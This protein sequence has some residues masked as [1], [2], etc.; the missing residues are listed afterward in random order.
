[1]KL[2]EKN[3][4]NFSVYSIGIGD[5]YDKD[6]IKNAGILGKGNYNFCNK[7]DELN[8]IIATEISKSISPY[9]SKLNI[10]TSLD[11]KDIIKDNKIK[12]IIREDEIISLNYITK[13]EKIDKIKIDINYLEDDKKIKKTFDIIPLEITEGEEFSKLIYNKYLLNS[14]S[15]LNEKEKINLALKYQIFI[16]N[17]SLFAEIELSEKVSPEM[18]SIIIGNRQNNIIIDEP[19]PYYPI[20]DQ[21]KNAFEIPFINYDNCLLE[22]CARG[23]SK[24]F[25]VENIPL[26][27]NTLNKNRGRGRIKKEK[28]KIKESKD[29]S[30]LG[31][32]KSKETKN[33]LKDDVMKIINTQ[34]FVEGFWSENEQ[35]KIILKKYKKEYDLIKKLKNKNINDNVAIT[36]VIIYFIYKEHTELLK[37]LSRIIK[38]AKLF[39]KKETKITYDN[40]IKEI[41][42]K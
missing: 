14:D 38:K 27:L 13:E 36:V 41:G 8:S 24:P 29:D 34:N 7:L 39:I 21:F 1:M 33:D 40:I 19:K 10:N 2:I 20:I 9:I 32:K 12:N 6:L 18:K 16:K 42:A 30:E 3:S 28:E 15:E 25:E 4:N 5:S 26:T 23:I 35:T 11:K 17:T 31:I 22:N 37:E